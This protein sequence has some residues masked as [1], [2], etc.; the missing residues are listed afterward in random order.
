MASAL[1][2]VVSCG[3][4]SAE[5]SSFAPVA[6]SVNIHHLAFTL[7]RV[8][9]VVD[10]LEGSFDESRQGRDQTIGECKIACLTGEKAKGRRSRNPR[11]ARCAC[12]GKLG[13]VLYDKRQLVLTP[14]IPF[15]AWG[16]L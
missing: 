13:R 2:A 12:H 6:L 7:T 9:G 11:R 16:L 10:N 4:V 3:V 14:K 15:Q 5:P 8:S 1:P